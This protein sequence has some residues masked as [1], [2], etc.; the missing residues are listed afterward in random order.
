MESLETEVRGLSRL[1][2]QAQAP[3]MAILPHNTSEY[4]E[5]AQQGGADAMI[6]GI[7]K[8][9]SMF[10]GLFGS[11]DLQEDSILGIVSTSSIPVG[12][13]IGDSRPLTPDGW[14]RIVSKPFSF[15]NMYAHHMPPFVLSDTRIDKLVS[16]GS[17]YMVEQIKSLAEMEQVKALEAAIVSAQ[18]MT[19]VFSVLDLSTLRMITRLSTKPVILRAQKR[20]EAGDFKSITE[21]GLR[22][23]CLDPSA[24]EPGLE[25]YRDAIT[26]FRSRVTSSVQ[27]NR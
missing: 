19:H 25:A 9:E 18:G 27:A 17:G 5:A 14:E 23:I 16:I 7:D 22:G 21:A 15:V 1:L 3:L 8:T 26:T 12:I 13:S 24:L 10:P 6:L 2:N 20:L 4:A 11:F